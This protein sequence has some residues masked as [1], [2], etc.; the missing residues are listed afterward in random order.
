MRFTAVGSVATVAALVASSVMIA[1]P[2]SAE[3][4]CGVARPSVSHLETAQSDTEYTAR[5]T[6]SMSLD[7]LQSLRCRG[8]WL[9]IE[10]VLYRTDSLGH[11]FNNY[12]VT[13]NAPGAVRD[14]SFQDKLPTPAA[15]GIETSRLQADRDYSIEIDWPK[16]WSGDETPVA[17]VNFVPSRWADTRN[18][19]ENI[20][21]NGAG[22]FWHAISG[23]AA[24]KRWCIFPTG[25][26][27]LI[28]SDHYP[29]V[30]NPVDGSSYSFVY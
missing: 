17:F 15:T 7:E 1:G 24:R 5:Y 2:A 16:Y 19:R 30:G 20:S 27:T 21:C 23:D 4:D 11:S 10:F 8:Q 26:S 9:E 14:E 13:S 3:R 22:A 18:R 6:F 28:T 12:S 25:D 29:G